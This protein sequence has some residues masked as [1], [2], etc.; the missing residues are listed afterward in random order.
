MCPRLRSPNDC[1]KSGGNL[2]PRSVQ[3]KQTRGAE[4]NGE[5]VLPKNGKVHNV[6]HI[7]IYYVFMFAPFWPWHGS[8]LSHDCSLAIKIRDLRNDIGDIAIS[9]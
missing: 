7:H 3:P 9:E 4:K 6:L 8:E 5:I 1:D 2:T